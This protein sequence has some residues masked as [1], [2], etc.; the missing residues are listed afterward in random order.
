MHKITRRH[1]PE[2]FIVTKKKIPPNYSELLKLNLRINLECSVPISVARK[3]CI[4]QAM[5]KEFLLFIDDDLFPFDDILSELLLN[6]EKNVG[7]V[8]G[9]PFVKGLGKWFDNSLNVH[10]MHKIDLKSGNRGFTIVTLVRVNAVRDWN[11]PRLV[12]FEDYD[13]SQHVLQKGYRWIKVPVSAVHIKSWRKTAKNAIW[14]YKGRG[15]YFKPTFKE[16]V[17]KIFKLIISSFSMARYNT[18]PFLLVYRIFFHFFCVIGVI[19]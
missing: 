4:D 19:S 11:P 18:D 3:K 17:T 5:T 15:Q 12:S 13:M 14:G 16:R 2:I 10:R 8:E 9:I 6:V 7:A 1:N